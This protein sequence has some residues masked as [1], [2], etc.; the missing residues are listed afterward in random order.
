MCGKCDPM[1]IFLTGNFSETVKQ[2][3][4][5]FYLNLIISHSYNIDE[6][7]NVVFLGVFIRR[8]KPLLMLCHI[9]SPFKSEL[10]ICTYW[11]ISSGTF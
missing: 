9:E 7:S 1:P 3:Y 10:L 4:T 11:I 2:N 6:R 8:I 5:Q